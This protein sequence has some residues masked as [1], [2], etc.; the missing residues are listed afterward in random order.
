[1]RVLAEWLDS[2]RRERGA[3]LMGVLNTTPDSFFDGGRYESARAAETHVD[4]L[5]AEG[6]EIVDI[7]AESSRPGAEPV[8]PAVQI[9]RMAAGL[10]RAVERGA[11]VSVDTTSAEVAEHALSRGARIVNDVSCLS[12]DEL[13]RVAARHGAAL[14]V[15]HT[16]GSLQD[17]PGFSAYPENGYADV[18]REVRAELTSARERAVR[19][20]LPEWDVWLDPGLGFKK[21]A[22]H[23]FE[24]LARLPELVA[25]G[26]PIVV[27]P[28][29]K[30]FIASVD[31]APPEQR[32]GG[33]VAACVVAAERGA[34]VLRVHDVAAV[35]QA[36][37]VLRLA[38]PERAELEVGHA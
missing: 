23:S 1:V 8:A 24:L 17:Q 25:A 12:D 34:A 11:V 30:S 7:G 20:G 2:T 3:V 6:A 4:R 29:R 37:G 21:S 38:R 5:L 10:R 32:L 19:A 31:G 13:A 18:L 36:L 16:R 14:I 15:M 35:R 9:D 27:G 22:R 28:S 33:T 26:A